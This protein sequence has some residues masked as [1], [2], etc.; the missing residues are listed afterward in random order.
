MTRAVAAAV[1]HKDS[2]A[3]PASDAT[4]IAA[5]LKPQELGITLPQIVDRVEASL[6]QAH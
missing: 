4:S 2:A 5:N 3:R 1:H 6:K